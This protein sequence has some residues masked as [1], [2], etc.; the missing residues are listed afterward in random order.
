MATTVS[1]F[2]AID[3]TAVDAE[4]PITES[5][6]KQLRDNAY[7]INAG[8]QKTSETTA[9]KFLETAGSGVLQWTST[10]SLG[11]NGTKGNIALTT[12]AA[13]IAIVSNKKLICHIQGT[14]STNKLGGFMV[15]IDSSDDSFVS[16]QNSGTL[17]GSFVAIGGIIDGDTGTVDVDVTFT[18]QKNGSNYEFKAASSDSATGDL[19]YM[20]L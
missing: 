17:A 20:W 4:S 3:D 2:T 7:W 8:T 15:F 18:A 9:N 14:N 5:L 16:N 12:S 6:M 19:V 11:V 1:N 13:T 10:S